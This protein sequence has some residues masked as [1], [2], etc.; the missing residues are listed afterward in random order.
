M[1]ER[2]QFR[3]ERLEGLEARV[4]LSNR[5][6]IAPATVGK[7][8]TSAKTNSNQAVVDQVNQT[9]E[10]FTSDYLQ[11]QG[12]YLAN[13]AS[14]ANHTA[15]SHYVGQRV[16]LLAAQL[17][18]IF[19]HVPGSLNLAPKSSPGGPVVVQSFLRS[20]VNGP[21]PTSLLVA[22]EGRKG[23]TG[24]IPPAGTTGTTATLYTDQ[25]LSAIAT[26]QTITLN[27]VGFLVSHRFQKR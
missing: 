26:T 25:A 18:T 19:V 1:R 14:A 7:L 23:G 8:N 3:P 10:S 27:S 6:L 5:G 9:Y 21:A 2:R 22:L 15:F 4:V 13:G 17:T 11:A 12:A 16:K 20:Y 24:A